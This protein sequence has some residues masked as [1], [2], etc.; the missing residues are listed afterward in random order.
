MS[1]AAKA[2]VA[3]C[4]VA[5]PTLPLGEADA[6]VAA[7]DADCEAED[8]AEPLEVLLTELDSA[9]EVAASA[10]AVALRVPHTWFCSQTD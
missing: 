10:S 2:P 1:K 7:A 6:D 9:A 8:V 3:I 4:W 5:A